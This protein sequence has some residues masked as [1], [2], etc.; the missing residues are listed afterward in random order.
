M[1]DSFE[2]VVVS[3]MTTVGT[4]DSSYQ[5]LVSENGHEQIDLKVS[6]D[7]ITSARLLQFVHFVFGRIFVFALCTLFSPYLNLDDPPPPPP[8]VRMLRLNIACLTGM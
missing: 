1:A 5:S 4:E 7:D 6:F 2:K 8:V 3:P